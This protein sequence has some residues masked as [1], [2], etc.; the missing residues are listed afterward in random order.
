MLREYQNSPLLVLDDVGVERPTPHTVGVLQQVI[1][2]RYNDESAT[3]ITSNCASLADLAAHFCSLTEDTIAARRIVDR[4]AE[5]A[6]IVKIAAASF[7]SERG[8]AMRSQFNTESAACEKPA[9]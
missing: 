2:R 8:R 1:D 9:S 5:I 4:L 6:V 3:V 7:R